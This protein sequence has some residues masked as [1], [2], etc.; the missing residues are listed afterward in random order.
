M[1][2]FVVKY[3]SDGN[4]VWANYALVPYVG[5]YAS[6]TG[7]TADQQG[8]VYITGYY[9]YSISFGPD[10][11]GNQGNRGIFLAKYDSTGTPLWGR[12]PGG[13]GT[14]FGWTVCTEPGGNVLLSG[15]Y[16]SPFLNFGGY[17]VINT[18]VGFN[19]AFVARYDPNGNA[20]GA[21]GS[22][23]P[24]HEYGMAIAADPAGD[25]YATGYF[26][27]YSLDFSG[28]VITNAGS[29]D[30]FLAKL[31][32]D[33]LN[34]VP[35]QVEQP[36]VRLFP[37][38]ARDR[39]QVLSEGHSTIRIHDL[40]SRPILERGFVGTTTIDV[41]QFPAGIYLYELIRDGTVVKGKFIRE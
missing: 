26:G 28:Q 5:N 3:G 38:P 18:N 1:E 17:P 16:E 15:Y 32:G 13:T 19:D 10:S 6:G 34:S 29:Y 36:T 30:V 7:I 9:Q 11:L 12:S 39:V 31:S 27:S 35:T 23:G 21:I 14:D 33:V 22:G 37:N 4:C 41:A 2:V 40:A 25:L 8:S 20:L 24:D